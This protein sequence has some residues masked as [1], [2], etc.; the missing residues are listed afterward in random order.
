MTLGDLA[1]AEILATCLLLRS[2]PRS[3]AREGARV[4]ARLAFELTDGLALGASYDGRISENGQSHQAS[5]PI[6]GS[7]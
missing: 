5:A 1:S 2:K 3:T 4:G 6:G 7:F